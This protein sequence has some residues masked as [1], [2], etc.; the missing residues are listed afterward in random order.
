M[1]RRTFV[2]CLPACL[3]LAVRRTGPCGD[4][5][6]D[7]GAGITERAPQL[8]QL[9][10]TA[11]EIIIFARK[12]KLNFCSRGAALCGGIVPRC[13][14]VARCYS[15]CFFESYV[16]PPSLFKKLGAG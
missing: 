12:K 5:E 16:L 8:T 10:T 6:E 13:P 11:R 15:L 2:A 7:G 9:N 14:R 4:R 3:V 1:P